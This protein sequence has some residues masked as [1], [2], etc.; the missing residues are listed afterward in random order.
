[1]PASRSRAKWAARI[2]RAWQKNITSIVATGKE[3]IKAKAALP[4]GSFIAMVENDLPFG[5]ETAWKFMRI[6]KHPVIANVAHG[7]HLPLSWTTLSVLAE[8]PAATVLARIK[9]TSIYPEMD[10]HAADR[11]VERH[12]YERAPK[13]AVNTVRV[14]TTHGKIIIASPSYVRSPSPDPDDAPLLSPDTSAPTGKVPA[15]LQ[16]IAAEATNIIEPPVD[17][18]KILLAV[19]QAATPAERDRFRAYIGAAKEVAA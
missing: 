11:L 13:P 7:K 14:E 17:R 12:R 1:M 16:E 6:A 5:R 15:S 8:L 3:I 2:S 9:D 10:R 19:W 18:F 4:H